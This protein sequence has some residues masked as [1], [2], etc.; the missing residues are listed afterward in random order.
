MNLIE[1]AKNCVS[2]IVNY[3]PLYAPENNLSARDKW[4]QYKYW[5]R[6]YMT[7]ASMTFKVGG[8]IKLV[9]YII[10]YPWL[11]DMVKC[12]AM[13]QRALYGRSGNYREAVCVAFD[14]VGRSPRPTRWFCR[15]TWFRRRSCAPWV[16][17]T[18]FPRSSASWA[19]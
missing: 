10:E 5:V 14:E 8:P 4:L 17:T 9:K 3:K 13:F 11:Y 15:K 12:N 18:G 7:V 19:P 1:I 16:C 6:N 2:D